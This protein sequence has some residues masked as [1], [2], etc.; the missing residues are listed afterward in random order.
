MPQSLNSLPVDQLTTLSSD[1]QSGK[2]SQESYKIMQNLDDESLHQI[3]AFDQSK[4]ASA[5]PIQPVQAAPNLSSPPSNAPIPPRSL[6][7][8]V[9]NSPIVSG[10][11]AI[12]AGAGD[13]INRSIASTEQFATDLAT[14]LG[15]SQA[16][17][18]AIDT[19][20]SNITNANIA[21]KPEFLQ[22]AQA[23]HPI[24]SGI[25]NAI[26]GTMAIGATGAIT[27]PLSPMKAAIASNALIGSITAGDQNRLLGA[28]VGAAIG[29]ATGLLG[30]A[31]SAVASK[32]PT[33]ILKTKISDY[34]TQANDYLKGTTTTQAAQESVANNVNLIRAVRNDYYKPITQST[35]GI[36]PNVVKALSDKVAKLGSPALDQQV[37]NIKNLG[38]LNNF[39]QQLGDNYFT[40]IS[41]DQPL[42]V[43]Q[44]FSDAQDFTK[45]NVQSLASKV[46]LADQLRAADTFN[47]SVV[48]PLQKSGMMKIADG[49][50][51]VDSLLSRFIKDPS[52][53]MPEGSP[54]KLGQLLDGMDA[55][56]RQIVTS[57]ILSKIAHSVNV[58]TDGFAPSKG[59][60]IIDSYKNLYGDQLGPESIKTL[61]GMKEILKKGIQT[62]STAQ[63]AVGGAGAVI[64][65]HLGAAAAGGAV[66]GLHAG[67]IGA[68]IGAT[69]APMAQDLIS[70][71]ASSGAGQKVLQ[72]IG[73]GN[74]SKLAGE[75]IAH[76]MASISGSSVNTLQK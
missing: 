45:S 34:L 24:L 9:A 1:M 49:K 57:N 6:L 65:N 38:D 40:Y 26:G 21:N 13:T 59:L 16:H 32:I 37:S 23:E 74:G 22:Q 67:P 15:L 4:V 50:T 46:G 51:N 29:G 53:S 72:A 47:A 44:A 36:E 76:Y 41:K 62:P 61:D 56:G 75:A 33:P 39:K 7:S 68:V 60:G 20:T 11:N 18:T 19:A 63:N 17:K 25:G 28:G 64:K 8:K 55:N 35:A 27:G 10:I 71:L 14:H 12:G 43:R 42:D 3:H 52:K 30:K 69:L 48:S 66:G 58:G 2:Y 31:I 54:Q 5:Q 73:T 70:S